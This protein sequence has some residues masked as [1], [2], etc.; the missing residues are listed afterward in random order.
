MT[1]LILSPTVNEFHFNKPFLSLATNIGLLVG[2]ILWSFGCDIWGRKSVLRRIP[3]RLLRL[4]NSPFHRRW[5]F[6]LTLLIGGVFGIAMGGSL[7]FVALASLAAI[8]GVGVGGNIPVDS[9]VFLGLFILCCSFRHVDAFVDFI[10]CSHQYLLTFMS[11]W[12]AFGQL[13][14][15]LVCPAY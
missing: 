6:N 8:T 1:G 12:W 15:S 5:S 14:G 4:L 3:L 13:F 2:T 10:P 11:I 7:T 9:V